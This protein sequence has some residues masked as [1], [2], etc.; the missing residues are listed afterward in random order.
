MYDPCRIA[1]FEWYSCS[2][3]STIATVRLFIV[4]P[5]Q[6]ILASGIFL[7]EDQLSHC[8]SSPLVFT[9]HP[10]ARKSRTSLGRSQAGYYR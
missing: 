10:P 1:N 3:A 7:P 4:K 9:H 5:R 2:A 6:E 8:Q